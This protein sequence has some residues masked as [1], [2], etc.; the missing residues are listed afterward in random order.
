MSRRADSPPAGAALLAQPPIPN[1]AIT[2]VRPRLWTLDAQYHCAIVGTCLG[3]DEL[4]RIARRCGF[5]APLDD[6]F[7]LHVEAVSHARSRN[8]SSEAIQRHLDAKY[9][10][11]VA[12]LARLRNDA[13]LR[14]AWRTSV[15]GGDVAGPLWAIS[16]HR[17]ASPATLQALYQDI[18]MLSH[19]VGAGLASDTRRLVALETENTEL[20]RGLKRELAALRRQLAAAESGLAERDALRA[21]ARALR[22]RLERFESGQVIIELGRRLMS[23]QGADEKL[24]ASTRRLHELENT[25]RDAQQLAREL[26]DARDTALA[27]RAALERLLQASLPSTTDDTLCT[28]AGSDDCAGCSDAPS[29]R[30]ILYVGGRATLI[31]QYRQLAGRLG[32]RLIHHDGGLEESLSRL[33][34][35]IGSADAVLCP[36]DK[37]SHNAYHHVKSHCKKA[38]KPC[39]FYP[40]GGVSGFA[41][42][43]E[44]VRRGEYSVAGGGETN[45]APLSSPP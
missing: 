10:A 21:D 45:T 36:T 5:A 42:A 40:G 13:A 6:A 31:A 32:I 3:L 25:L 24:A 39:L 11:V 9:R 38:G 2:R 34:D 19:Q 7:A 16:T 14:D 44:R 8:P 12:R 27:E 20:K 26:A 22:N 29:A 30:C 17:A 37:V 18:H 4:Q 33:P 15:R 43:V 28:R 1:S 35:M 41:V 23:L